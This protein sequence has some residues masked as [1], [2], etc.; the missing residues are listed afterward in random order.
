MSRLVTRSAD[1]VYKSD[2]RKYL[3]FLY[4]KDVGQGG[5]HALHQNAFSGQLSL[6][7]CVKDFAG[8]QAHSD[9]LSGRT[10]ANAWAL[11]I[12]PEA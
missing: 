11:A 4:P 9:V 5:L 7:L 12:K 10:T 8:A 2:L 3:L 1:V 6:P